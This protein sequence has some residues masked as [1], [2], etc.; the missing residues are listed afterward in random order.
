MQV[1]TESTLYIL[2]NVSTPTVLVPAL[3]VSARVCP[4]VILTIVSGAPIMGW[5][6]FK[7]AR[8]DTRKAVFHGLL[9]L[10]RLGTDACCTY[11]HLQSSINSLSVTSFSL[12]SF[13]FTL[14][15]LVLSVLC[16]IL[17][18]RHWISRLH[19]LA[20][21]ISNGPFGFIREDPQMER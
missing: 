1:C 2:Y 19:S 12:Y 21:W 6:I 14:S 17:T 13:A 5:S 9:Q 10:A 3:L 11:F 18:A 16:R 20:G 15:F 7:R 8:F 4:N